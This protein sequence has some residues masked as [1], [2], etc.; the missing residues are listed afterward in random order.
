[1]TFQCY[2]AY[3]LPILGFL[4]TRV[5]LGPGSCTCYMYICSSKAFWRNL[6][7]LRK[8]RSYQGPLKSKKKM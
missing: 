7:Q 1:M 5:S 2:C 6:E 4:A 8:G 3:I